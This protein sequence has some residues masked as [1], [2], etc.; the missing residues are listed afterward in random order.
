M[1]RQQQRGS[2]TD[3]RSPIPRDAGRPGGGF[4]ATGSAERP[5]PLC[6]GVGVRLSYG[7][8]RVLD[9]CDLSVSPRQVVGLTGENGS[10]KSTLVKCLL[11]FLRPTAGQVR[12][13]PLVGYCPQENYL[14]RSYAVAEHLELI[15]SL[16]RGGEP[17]DAAWLNHCVATLKLERYLS[18]PIRKLSGGTYQK[19]KLMTAIV[20]RPPLLV[21]DEPTDGFDWTMYLVFWDLIAELV[22]RGTGVLMISH[23]LHDRDRFDRI[24]DLREGRLC[25]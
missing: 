19:V 10:G 14:H 23:L 22:G 25:A 6:S 5:D 13:D 8:H 15:G 11:G 7:K 12:C 17:V 4:A 21:L 3:Q 2:M 1:I 20:H 18:Y 9:G 24:Y 16:S